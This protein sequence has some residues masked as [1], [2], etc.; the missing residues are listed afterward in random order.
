MTKNKLLRWMHIWTIAS[1][2]KNLELS[3]LHRQ[4]TNRGF[5]TSPRTTRRDINEMEELGFL[6]IGFTDGRISALL[7]W[8][9]GERHGAGG[10]HSKPCR[11]FSRDD[12]NATEATPP[13]SQ[14]TRR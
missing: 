10:D 5:R 3:T 11:A 2:E 14:S 12:E 8:G 7:R 4:L 1:E 9:N 6:S 13:K